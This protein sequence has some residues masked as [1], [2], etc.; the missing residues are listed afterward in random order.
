MGQHLT[1]EKIYEVLDK[2][3]HTPIHDIWLALVTELFGYLKLK[4]FIEE[5]IQRPFD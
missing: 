2:F 5:Q 4:P 3:P 1:P